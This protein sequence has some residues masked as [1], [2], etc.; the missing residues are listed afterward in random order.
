MTSAIGRKAEGGWG[1]PF[2][3]TTHT[4]IHTY[5]QLTPTTIIRTTTIEAGWLLSSCEP[6]ACHFLCDDM[7]ISIPSIPSSSSSRAQIDYTLTQAT[8]LLADFLRNGNG[9]TML[10]TGAGVSVDSGIAPY[11]GEHGHYSE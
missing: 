11:R 9:K 3:R 4:R 6:P 2:R 10:M 7:R 5:I 8:D 1:D